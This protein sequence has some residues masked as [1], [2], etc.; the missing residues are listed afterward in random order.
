MGG[1]FLQPDVI[2]VMKAGFIII[3]EHGRRNMH[4]VAE[5]KAF[6]N[7]ALPNA[8][9]HLWRYIDKGPSSG[10]FKPQFFAIAF[11]I[12]PPRC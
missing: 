11:H 1:Q 8:V 7:T 9:L 10:Y 5:Y 6:C 4:G 2:V 12:L 3:D